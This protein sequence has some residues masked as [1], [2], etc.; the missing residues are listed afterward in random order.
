MVKSSFNN[1]GICK[2]QR[3]SQSF[4]RFLSILVSLLLLLT[5]FSTLFVP[6]LTAKNGSPGSEKGPVSEPIATKAESSSQSNSGSSQTDTTES[7]SSA[8]TPPSDTKGKPSS[9]GEQNPSDSSKE[10]SQPSENVD[11]NPS[12]PSSDN[13][14]QPS[15]SSQTAKH[16]APSPLSSSPETNGVTKDENDYGNQANKT[17]NLN[18]QNN[19][20]I[21]SENN[22]SATNENP[23]KNHPSSKFTFEEKTD[24]PGEN[25]AK[26]Y[27]S[28]LGNISKDQTFSVTTNKPTNS[29]SPNPHQKTTI[30]KVEFKASSS[31]NNV[32]LSVKN[33]E[34]KPNE[35]KTNISLNSTQAEIYE[36][37]DIKLTAGETYIGETG[38]Q[39]MNFTF[40][41]T[42]SWIEN[43]SIDKHTVKMM[44]YHNDTWQTLNTTYVNETD[45][46]IRFK[47]ETPGLSIFAVVGDKVV[48]DSD[49]IIVEST[50]MPWW[51]PMSV[52]IG[53]TA[54]LGVVLF[55]KR[56]VYN[57]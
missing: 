39:T 1:I 31:Q 3:T 26:Q 12:N 45:G 46:E 15:S 28:Q 20:N 22:P 24:K 9:D 35:V 34:E 10:S 37:L 53:S 38:I 49:E 25:I 44:R 41:V 7:T 33:L 14:P 42:R 8:S 2:K 13:S 17:P 51:M 18:P 30:E 47:A 57:P 50:N 27:S 55:K 40:T 19:Q 56:F 23:S 6:V 32:E 36:Y 21:D 11:M 52:I 5:V 29:E 4:S 54:T 43:R 48:E 16:S